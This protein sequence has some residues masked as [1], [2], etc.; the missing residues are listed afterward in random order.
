MAY[1]RIATHPRIF[2]APLSADEALANISAII[3]LPHVRTISELDGFLDACRYATG[4][5][6]VRGNLVPDAHLA[7]ILFQN[8]VRVLYSNDRDFMKFS[9][10]DLRDPF[11]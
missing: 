1:L 10:V 2:A 3:G 5:T 6:P 7:T 9:S 11:T 4:A 8:G